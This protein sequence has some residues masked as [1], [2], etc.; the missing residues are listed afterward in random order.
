MFKRDGIWWVSITFRGRRIRRSTE[1]SSLEL[2]K[3]IESKL[4]TELTEEK[5]F[6]KCVGA[7]KTFKEM[8]DCFVLEYAPKNSKRAQMY[9]KTTLGHP[10]HFF[11]SM[12]LTSITPKKIAEYKVM[13][14]TNGVKPGTVN[15]ERS[16]FSKMFNLAIREWE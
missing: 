16:M 3:A 14:Y 1:T 2:A 8:A 12:K 11:G 5:Y 7:E 10:L 6:D 9:Y 13:M 15:L 4:R